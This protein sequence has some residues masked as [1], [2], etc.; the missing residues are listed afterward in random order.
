MQR[1]MQMNV[2]VT[3]PVY[4]KDPQGTDLGRRIIEHSVILID[5][6]GLEK[7]TFG[8]LAA[9][10][11]TAESSIYR[12][13][14]NK[15]RLLIY[16]VGWYWSWREYKL[17]FDTANIADPLTRL[18]RGV[19]SVTEPISDKGS[20]GYLDLRALYR[21]AISESSKAYMTKEVDEEHKEGCFSGFKRLC[22]RV[23]DLVLAVAPEHPYPAALASNVV[24]GSMVQRFFADHLPSLTDRSVKARLS[25]HFVHL[26][27]ASVNAPSR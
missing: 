5:E 14:D 1:L 11:G 15:H 23:R 24:D 18:E 21:I 9:A 19:R 16:L 7:F 27:F 2:Q 8:K 17:V 4:L 10:L 6:L 26:V 3:E 13:F 22:D 12:Y 20:F 25:D